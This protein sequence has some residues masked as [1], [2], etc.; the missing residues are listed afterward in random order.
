MTTIHPSTLTFLKDL[1]KNNNREWFQENRKRYETTKG[2]VFEFATEFLEAAAEIDPTLAD[3]EPKKCIFRINRDI[4]FSKDKSPY[5]IN[6]GISFNKGG[7]KA[8]TAGYYLNIEPNGT[9]MGGGNYMV[10]PVELKKIR[11]EIDYNLAEFEGII[12]DKA[13]VDYYGEIAVEEK[14]SLKRPP[15]ILP[16][17]G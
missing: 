9:F 8:P 4:R 14:L 13:F 15:I 1:A 17:N 12:T 6:M 16:S 11:E 5:K 2:N 3:L 7:K 10:Q